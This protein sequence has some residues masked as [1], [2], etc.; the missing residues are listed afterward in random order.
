MASAPEDPVGFKPIDGGWG[1]VVVFGAH[2]SIGFAYSL[3][4]ALSI[5]FKE[6]QDDLGTSFSEI[7]LISSVMLAA[8]YGGG[9]VSSLLVNRYG[10]RTVVMV[11]GLMSGL[12]VAAASLATS[13]S[14]LY[15]FV[16]IIGGCG[17]AFNLN[18]SVTIISK[19]FLVRRPLAN[20]LAMA[21]SP[22]F[23]CGLA[24]LNQ[25]LLNMFGWRGSLLI[26]GGLMLNS[27]VAGALMR[28]AGSPPVR[29]LAGE[30]KEMEKKTGFRSCVKNVQTF[31]DLSIFKD[32]GFVIYIIGNVMF[33]F[34]AY[35]PFLFLAEYAITQGVDDYS[36]AFLLSIVGFVDIFTR[37]ATGLLA[38]C[39]WIRLR[40]QYLFSFAVI[41]NGLSHLLC[42][43]LNGYFYL[44]V[45]AILFG[46]SFGMVFALIFE[47][48]LDLIGIQ[49][50]PSAVG[51][52]TI[53]EC[54]PVL[55]GPPAA[56]FLVDVLQ[57]YKYL[58]FMCGT[59]I[60]TGGVF[61]LVMNIYNYHQV[62]PEE[63]TIDL[64]QNRKNSENP[65]Q[66]TKRDSE[67][68]TEPAE[69]NAE[70]GYPEFLFY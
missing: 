60:L 46:W 10:C 23:L 70:T 61:L 51:L 26:I 64:E 28:P 50:F 43:L 59:V 14:F 18:A 34:G 42:P 56:G 4:K 53:I 41:L 44:V 16:G 29:S 7:A 31:M 66:V 33:F 24:P 47:C 68:V 38:S 21:G 1:W 3:P 36:A 69:P 20:G 57:D 11:G 62:C 39:K 2:I 15:L 19:Y 37:P 8:V 5:F 48:L 6:I 27:C 55:V 67:N 30:Q 17:L 63:A 22:V 65:D 45:Y 40:I 58:F 12:S 52:V 35:A 49:R 13:I 54:F 25:Y 9:P 32:R